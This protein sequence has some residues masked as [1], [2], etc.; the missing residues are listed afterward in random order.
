M[1]QHLRPLSASTLQLMVHLPKAVPAGMALAP[2]AYLL[3][4]L[5]D[6]TTRHLSSKSAVPFGKAQ[7]AFH[8]GE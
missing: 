3:T 5:L 2:Q 7:L 6:A 1:Y 8:T 4:G